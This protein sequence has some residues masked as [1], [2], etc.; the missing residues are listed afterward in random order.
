MG[1][2]SFDYTCPKCGERKVGEV[3][4]ETLKD[5]VTCDNCCGNHAKPTLM[6]RDDSAPHTF[7]AIIPTYT[8]SAR[9]KA[10]Y[11][12]KHVDRPST[13]TQVGYGGSVSA[14]HPTGSTKNKD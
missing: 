4:E 6:A 13:K 5:E 14:D 10:G 9:F 1:W 12:H 7:T 2:K 11:Q 8:G 3:V